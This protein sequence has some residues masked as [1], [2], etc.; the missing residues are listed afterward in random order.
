[1]QKYGSLCWNFPH[2][3]TTSDYMGSLMVIKSVCSGF[4]DE[5]YQCNIDREEIQKLSGIN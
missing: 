2:T 1:M 3:F 5:E 4:K